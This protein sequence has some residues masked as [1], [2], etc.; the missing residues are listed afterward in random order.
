MV[1]L[2][3]GSTR[4]SGSSPSLLGVKKDVKPGADSRFGGASDAPK[5]IDCV[6]LQ[7]VTLTRTCTDHHPFRDASLHNRVEANKSAADDEEHVR[8]VDVDR[9]L[10]CCGG[11]AF[12]SL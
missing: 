12:S 3:D 7:R 6:L 2:P 5:P 11:S 9:I 10:S 8:G 1:T 4:F